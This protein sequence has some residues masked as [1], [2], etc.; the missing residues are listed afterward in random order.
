MK[1]LFFALPLNNNAVRS[2]KPV[3]DHLKR[4][5]S[6]L[7][8]VEPENYHI[9]LKFLGDT[10][11]GTA[12]RLKEKIELKD[13]N[14]KEVHVTVKGLGVFPDIKRPGVIWSGLICGESILNVKDFIENISSECGFEED[15]RKFHPHLTLAR[16]RKGKRTEKDLVE[17][18]INNSDTEYK[19]TILR[20][21][22]LFESKLTPAGPVYSELA[23]MNLN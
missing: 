1:R 10:D 19:N 21:A 11:K 20:K 7:K 16:V 15:R 22:V 13:N 2:L 3:Y 9:T 18:I 14:F 23:C 17:Y 5:S 12:D 6:Y 8:L 4:F